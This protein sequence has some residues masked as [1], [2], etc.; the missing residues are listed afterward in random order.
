MVNSYCKTK[1]LPFGNDCDKNWKIYDYYN[2]DLT[3][4]ESVTLDCKI[5][6]I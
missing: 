6:N 4:D 3:D 2:K 1:D 5:E